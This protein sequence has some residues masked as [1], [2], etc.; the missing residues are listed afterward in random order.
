MST[1]S[2]LLACPDDILL[3]I[4]EQCETGSISNLSLACKALRPRCIP[5]LYREVDLSSHNIGRFSEHEGPTIRPEYQLWTHLN[6]S[7]RPE[8]L[9]PAQRSF[10]RTLCEYPDYAKYIRSFTWTLIWYDEHAKEEPRAMTE[11]DY[12]TWDVFSRMERVETLDLAAIALDK[13]W[14]DYCREPPPTLFPRVTDLR[15]VGWF[16][17]KIVVNIFNSIDLSKLRALRLDS[18]QEEGRD[19]NG[20]P[21]SEDFNKQHWEDQK[22]AQ[23]CEDRRKGVTPADDGIIYPGPMWIPFL[24]LIGRFTSLQS[25]EIAIPPLEDASNGSSLSD[26]P[27]CPDYTT[28][29]SVMEELIDS[30]SPSLEQLSIEYARAAEPHGGLTSGTLSLRMGNAEPILNSFFSR[31]GIDDCKWKPLKSVS[32]RGFLERKDLVRDPPERANRYFRGRWLGP[33]NLERMRNMRAVQARI[34]AF[35]SSKGGSLEWVDGS[36]RPVFNYMG[37]I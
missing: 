30:V 22:R 13:S 33:S 35:V 16:P 4:L 17:H 14:D 15:L 32:L 8:T 26:S 24:P 27:V 11:I 29:I 21:V 25:L 6:D 7:H 1:R 19:S 9:L 36:P 20:S 28:Y 18:L 34:E 3:L 10:L 5:Q 31:F 2:P 12:H 23:L 37:Y